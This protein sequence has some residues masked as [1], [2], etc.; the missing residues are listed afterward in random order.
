MQIPQQAD[1]FKPVNSSQQGHLCRGFRAGMTMVCGGL[2]LC[3]SGKAH[4]GEGVAEKGR[5]VVGEGVDIC[6]TSTTALAN[7]LPRGTAFFLSGR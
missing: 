4:P 5:G 6:H 3:D 7:H 2:D 1:T